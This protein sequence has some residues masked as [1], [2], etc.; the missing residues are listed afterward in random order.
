M[1]FVTLDALK[2]AELAKRKTKMLAMIDSSTTPECVRYGF[3]LLSQHPGGTPAVT[4]GR[5]RMSLICC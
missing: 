1:A 4:A 5:L 3:R 2:K